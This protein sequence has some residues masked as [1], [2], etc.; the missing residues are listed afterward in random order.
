MAFGSVSLGTLLAAP[1]ASAGEQTRRDVFGSPDLLFYASFDKAGHADLNPIQG[2]YT[3]LGKAGRYPNADY[4]R[5]NRVPLIERNVQMHEAGRFGQAMRLR[6]DLP[7]YPASHGGML[8]FEGKRNVNLRCGT[9]AFWV[10][11]IND[12]DRHVPSRRR[13]LFWIG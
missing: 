4:A 2:P 3:K 12:W 6:A 11:P 9:L 10:K 5:G 8:A 7:G 1:A 13:F